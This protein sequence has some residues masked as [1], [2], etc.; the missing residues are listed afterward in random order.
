MTNQQQQPDPAADD[1]LDI[2]KDIAHAVHDRLSD[3][4]DGMVRVAAYRVFRRC[5]GDMLDELRHDLEEMVRVALAERL[6]QEQDEEEEVVS[7]DQE[8]D[9]GEDDG[10]GRPIEQPVTEEEEP[11]HT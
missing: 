10:D 1:L 6:D 7:E 5:R 2:A 3:E 11:K 8:D 9:H 4:L